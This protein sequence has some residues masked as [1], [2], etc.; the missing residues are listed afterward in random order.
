MPLGVAVTRQP[1]DWVTLCVD[2]PTDI[3]PVRVVVNPLAGTTYS[4]RPLPVPES[5]LV[6][7]IKSGELLT[8]VHEQA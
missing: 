1:A 5:P 8:A 6:N 4:T 2:P 7:W 3:E